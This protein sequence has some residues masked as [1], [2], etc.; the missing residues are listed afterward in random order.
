MAASIRIINLLS[1]N[2]IHKCSKARLIKLYKR[3]GAL[4][5]KAL[6]INRAA[7]RLFSCCLLSLCNH[8]IARLA[9][10]STKST[11]KV[12][13]GVANFPKVL[14]ACFIIVKSL[15]KINAPR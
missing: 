4:S 3:L 5:A 13:P 10:K 15:D 8:S 9:S 12:P 11:V 7:W 14:V 1:R 2:G 6:M